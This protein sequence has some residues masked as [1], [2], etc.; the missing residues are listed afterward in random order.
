MILKAFIPWHQLGLSRTAAPRRFAD[1]GRGY[2]FL[3]LA[4]DV[5]QRSSPPRSRWSNPASWLPVRL[6][7]AAR[8]WPAAGSG[9]AGL[10]SAPIEPLPLRPGRAAAS[11]VPARNRGGSSCRCGPPAGRRR[12]SDSRRNRTRV[13]CSLIAIQPVGR[14]ARIQRLERRQIVAG[15]DRRWC[16]PRGCTRCDP[17]LLQR[18][19]PGARRPG[20]SRGPIRSRCAAARRARAG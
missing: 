13:I 12:A 14:L 2:G 16:G 5:A 15:A 11:A 1:R 17:P 10:R 6:G 3:P 4:L 19:R 20:P 7:G 18:R 8:D 9:R